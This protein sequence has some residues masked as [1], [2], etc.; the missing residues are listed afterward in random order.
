MVTALKNRTNQR[1]PMHVVVGM[2]SLTANHIITTLVCI[3]LVLKQI[4]DTIS[5]YISFKYLFS[6]YYV[7]LVVSNNNG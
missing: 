2:G 7:V 3:F 6:L 5:T 4:P 1:M